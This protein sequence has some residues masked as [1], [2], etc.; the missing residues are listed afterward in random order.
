MSYDP[1]SP[2]WLAKALGLNAAGNTGSTL[3]SLPP[4]VIH[5]MDYFT[6]PDYL[7]PKNGNDNV[8]TDPTPKMQPP[9]IEVKEEAGLHPVSGKMIDVHGT[10]Q[11]TAHQFS[12]IPDVHIGSIKHNINK[13]V[14][15][16][17]QAEDEI[18]SH[19]LQVQ[20]ASTVAS[21]SQ[22]SLPSPQ[23][24]I[25][26]HSFQPKAP[27]TTQKPRKERGKRFETWQREGLEVQYSVSDHLTQEDRQHLEKQLN[28]SGYQIT[29]WF[30]NRRYKERK[31]MLGELPL[32]TASSSRM[33][34]N[35]QQ[36]SSNAPSPQYYTSSHQSS[37][38]PQSSCEQ[39]ET[40]KERDENDPI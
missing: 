32:N 25:A 36:S 26:Q 16:R 39:L 1:S 17:S 18:Q 10:D 34:L 15:P 11:H 2:Y 35:S 21:C 6:D 28:L 33:M 38:S 30:Q 20:S 29:T 13:A 9:T 23:F 19:D 3:T 40:I 8:N 5:S 27:E 4:L 12:Q 22:P 31:V 37:L 24:S 7:K 14:N